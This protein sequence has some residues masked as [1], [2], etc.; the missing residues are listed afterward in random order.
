MYFQFDYQIS[1]KGVFSKKNKAWSTPKLF[2]KTL[3]ECHYLQNNKS[4]K[5]YYSAT[6]KGKLIIRDVFCVET[7]GNDTITTS[8][9]FD[10]KGDC[11]TDFYISSDESYVIL[12]IFK[13]ENKEEYE[14]Y[15]DGVELF[16][17]FKNEGNLWSIPENLGNLSMDYRTGHGGLL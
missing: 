3:S 8:L 12:A 13:E 14:F 6:V 16:I 17:S 2:I 9:G 7:N 5:F 15:G 4:G 10:L 1:P 11:C